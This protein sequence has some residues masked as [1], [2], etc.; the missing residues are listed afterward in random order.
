MN[1]II[2]RIRSKITKPSEV[3]TQEFFSPRELKIL[4]ENTIKENDKIN[5]K[6]VI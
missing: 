3:E 4:K 2:S 6:I 1:K 5:I